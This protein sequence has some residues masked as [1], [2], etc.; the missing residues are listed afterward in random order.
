[1]RPGRMLPLTMAAGFLAATTLGQAA[2]GDV[3]TPA[4]DF[5]L[6]EFGTGET[7]TLSRHQGEVV[8]LFIIGYG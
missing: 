1:M 6:P 7:H 3:G 5:A 4:A 8:M 2:P